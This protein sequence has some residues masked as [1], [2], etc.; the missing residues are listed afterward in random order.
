[1]SDDD[2]ARYVVFDMRD[3]SRRTAGNAT[4]WQGA[5][6]LGAQKI[7]R[8]FRVKVPVEH[9]WAVAVYDGEMDEDAWKRAVKEKGGK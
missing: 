2:S 6:E 3:P 4:S 7:G 8:L 9:V 1:M 5:R